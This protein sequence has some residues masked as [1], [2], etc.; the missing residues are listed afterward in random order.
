VLLSE[1]AISDSNVVKN[2][3]N[4]QKVTVKWPGS[5][6][7][8]SEDGNTLE[9]VSFKVRSNQILAIFGPVGC[10]KVGIFS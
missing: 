4:C 9:N 7:D 5:S 1:E 6:S 10:G 8:K 2:Q 3:I